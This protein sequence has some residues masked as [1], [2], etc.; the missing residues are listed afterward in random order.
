MLNPIPTEDV[1]N[2][3][4]RFHLII[5]D[6][7]FFYLYVGKLSI[8][9]KKIRAM[10]G[11]Y[12]QS[13]FPPDL[14][15]D[16]TVYDNK[17]V[18]VAMLYRNEFK[19]LIDEN[20]ELFRKARRI[21]TMF[22]ELFI[23]YDTFLFTDGIRVYERK[24]ESVDIL[25]A[26]PEG[27]LSLNEVIGDMLPL[28]SDISL[29]NVRKRR[30]ALNKNQTLVAVIAA[31]YILFLLS[32]I[33]SNMAENKRLAAYEK[34]LS[35]LYAQAGVSNS[36]DPYGVLLSRAERRQPAPFR[37]LDVINI[38]GAGVIDEITLDSISLNERMIR[39]EGFAEDFAEME[40][41]KTSLESKLRKQITVE[42]SRQS[43]DRIRFTI[44]YDI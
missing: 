42:D 7:Y 9:R 10:V 25:S 15:A 19:E 12:I 26:T 39:I 32:G 3:G 23:R 1:L 22:A 5:D 35:S 24:T 20:I 21:S 6:S 40:K 41:L 34:Q 18:Y 16:F 36:P 11:N 44:R 37:A 33:V 28:R 2:S 31:C 30:E 4:N 14:F 13:M 27:T 17:G 29:P 43:G 8:N 38:L